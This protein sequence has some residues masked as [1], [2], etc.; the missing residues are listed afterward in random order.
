MDRERER[1]RDRGREREPAL[2]RPPAARHR[3][4]KHPPK[5]MKGA[6]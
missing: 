4:E 6:Y 3:N 1:K 5:Y 2:E